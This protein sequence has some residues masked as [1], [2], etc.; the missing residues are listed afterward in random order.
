MYIFESNVAHY[1]W[2]KEWTF[3][4]INENLR[5]QKGR[6]KMEVWKGRLLK[7]ILEVCMLFLAD[8]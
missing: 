6:D 8:P 4:S 2:H 7:G 3:M 1:N 5:W